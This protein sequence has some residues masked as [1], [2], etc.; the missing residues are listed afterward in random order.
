[1]A[2]AVTPETLLRLHTQANVIKARHT[3]LQ[4][5]VRERK[6]VEVDTLKA[7]AI[8]RGFRFRDRVMLAPARCAAVLAADHHVEPAAMAAALTQ[9]AVAALRAISTGPGRKRL[10]AEI[11]SRRD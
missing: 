1:M 6:V 11:R 8:A 3:D 2:V 4:T 10:E 7:A 9:F 5:K